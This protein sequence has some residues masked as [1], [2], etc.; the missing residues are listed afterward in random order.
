MSHWV[1]ATELRCSRRVRSPLNFRHN[2]AASLTSP[3]A[4]QMF[5]LDA[6]N[7]LITAYPLALV[8]LYAVPVSLILHGLVWQRLAARTPAV[9]AHRLAE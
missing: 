7:Q 3:G 9:I 5:A 4:A 1:I 6:P 8:P 2:V